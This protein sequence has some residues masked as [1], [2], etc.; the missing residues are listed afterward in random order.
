MRDIHTLL[1]YDRDG[2]GTLDAQELRPALKELGLETSEA[3]AEKI[4]RAWDA[5][6]SGKLD[7][8]EFTDLVRSLKAFK[9]YDKDGS[10]DIDADEL[11]E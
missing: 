11:I 2:S 10:G 7:L 8:L 9:K 3:A 1:T 5:D 6:G 4:V